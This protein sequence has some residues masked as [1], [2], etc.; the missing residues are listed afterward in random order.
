MQKIFVILIPTIVM[1][2][3][4]MKY[5]Q[6]VLRPFNTLVHELS[7]ALVALLLGEKIKE[8]KINPD[9]SG[10]CTTKSES[11]LK[12]FFVS[13][14]G[15]IVP[16]LLAYLIICELQNSMLDLV[17]YVLMFVSVFAL[18]LYVKNSFGIVWIVVF[19]MINAF[20]LY[21]PWFKDAQVYILYFYACILLTENTLSAL[22]LVSINLGSARDAGDSYNL[23]KITHI[24]AIFYSLLFFGFSVFMVYASFK[25][26]LTMI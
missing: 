11:R 10:S 7:H 5:I 15:Y 24:P 25:V 2:C 23:Q 14:V 6:A 3:I 12:S 8:I 19:C 4:R 26:V 9:Y 22:S 21:I 18:L 20:F 17:F 16:S 1:I 13:I